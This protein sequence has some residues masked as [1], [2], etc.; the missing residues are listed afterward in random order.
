MIQALLTKINETDLMQ[1]LA[2]ASLSEVANQGDEDALQGLQKVIADHAN[3]QENRAAACKLIA[4]LSPQG[5]A[6]ALKALES[7]KQ[8]AAERNEEL[9]RIAAEEAITK[10]GPSSS[11]CSLL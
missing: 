7:C 10:I 9:V 5:D 3:S 11:W 4:E 8:Q 2:I 6:E 1:K